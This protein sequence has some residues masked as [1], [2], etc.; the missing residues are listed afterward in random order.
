LRLFHTKAPEADQRD[1]EGYTPLHRAV[2]GNC[3]DAVQ[4]LVENKYDTSVQNKQGETPLDMAINLKRSPKMIQL[5]SDNKKTAGGLRQIYEHP[6]VTQYL[7][8]T[9]WVTGY[10][11]TFYVY[12]NLLLSYLMETNTLA[13]M[14]L[15]FCLVVHGCLYFYVAR[16]DPGYVGKEMALDFEKLID[17]IEGEGK[18]D[19]INSQQ[20][21]FTCDITKPMRSKHCRVC[22]RCVYRF[23]HHCG[24][25]GNCVGHKNHPV[26]VGF[27]VVQEVVHITTIYLA[28]VALRYLWADGVGILGNLTGNPIMIILLIM[29][30]TG[31][32]MTGALMKQ[33]IEMV[34]NNETTNEVM[35]WARYPHFWKPVVNSADGRR[36]LAYTNPFHQGYKSNVEHFCFGNPSEPEQKVYAKLDS[37][38]V[39]NR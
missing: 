26:F 30:L 24:W 5:L 13:N 4:F 18:T 2:Y 39:M 23:D 12:Y 15:G 35:N 21:C 20:I 1:N 10:F 6:K 38:F 25:V 34:L 28:I 37:V 3:E 14:I 17:N 27:L 16:S 29:H 7:F 11:F 36:G 9:V 8:P 19:K 22:D 33:H 32:V 31:V